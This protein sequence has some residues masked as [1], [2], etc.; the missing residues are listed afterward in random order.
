MRT[1]EVAIVGGGIAGLSAAHALS[2]H[3]P[4][5]PIEVLEAEPTLGYHT[6]GRS[7]AFLIENYGASSLRPLTLASKP[8]LLQPPSDLADRPLLTRRGYL[9]V[10]AP[11]E[12]GVIERLAVEGRA[13]NPGIAVIEPT[14]A[15]ALAPLLRPERVGRA[16]FEPEASSIDVAAL[17]QAFVRGFRAGD[18]VISAK[19]RFIGARR[20]GSGW[21]IRTTNGPVRA[22][23][24]INAAGAWGDVVAASAGIEPIGLLPLRRTAF[25]VGSRFPGSA[26]WPLVADAAHAWYISPDG[27]QFL[28]SPADETPSAPCDARPD[29]LDIALAIERINDATTL[30]VRSVRSSWAGLR[31]FSPDRG[32]VIGPDPAQPTFVW[33][34]GQGGT[35]IQTAPG[36]GR[37]VADL[38]VD[39]RPGPM[40]ESTGLDLGCILPDRFR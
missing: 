8:F 5:V 21:L 33:C 23:I 38:V 15:L 37:L 1:I 6:T 22:G 18:G 2:H 3:L 31:T 29:E 16:L 34:V 27:D 35:G 25:M 24:I 36:A 20:D 9:A 14:E 32:M 19:T 12:E 10:A 17:H 11:G 26:A 28:C 40:F 7:A 30:D 4:G 39:G 13:I